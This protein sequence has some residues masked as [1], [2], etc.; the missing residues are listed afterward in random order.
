MQN[1]EAVIDEET[2]WWQSV[3]MLAGWPEWQINPDAKGS[4]GK[5]KP[6]KI[7]TLEEKLKEQSNMKSF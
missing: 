3:A 6:I 5:K 7:K 4:D 1:I 2:E